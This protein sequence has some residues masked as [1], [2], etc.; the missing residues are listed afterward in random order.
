MNIRYIEE[1][2]FNL[3]KIEFI[4][5]KANAYVCYVFLEGYYPIGCNLILY[6]FLQSLI[7]DGTGFIMHAICVQ[8]YCYFLTYANFRATIVRESGFC[9]GNMKKLAVK[10]CELLLGSI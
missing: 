4:L 5:N 6:F 10:G 8:R 1:T 3:W 7:M 2:Y 9:R